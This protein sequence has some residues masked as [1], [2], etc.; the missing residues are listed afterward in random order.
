MIFVGITGPSGSGKSSLS[1]TLQDDFVLVG[2]DPATFLSGPVAT[3]YDRRDPSTELPSNVNW[4]Q[5][6]DQIDT[7]FSSARKC[8]SSSDN[9][10]GKDGVLI[11]HFL[12]PFVPKIEERLDLLVILDDLTIHDGH[13]LSLRGEKFR[14]RRVARNLDRS[15]DD[16]LHLRMYYDRSVWKSYCDVSRPAIDRLM[17]TL[18]V[19][20]VLQVDPLELD[21]N[22]LSFKV[23]DF[24]KKKRACALGMS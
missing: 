3:P 20:R 21:A 7:A 23:K 5:V 10:R 8:Q 16:K 15:E 24:V 9:S 11:E 1:K 13:D 19:D 4:K 2:E 18:P 6:V 12:L 17:L 14:E 22:E